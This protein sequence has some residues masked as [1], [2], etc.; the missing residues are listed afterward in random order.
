MIDNWQR[1]RAGV[2]ASA[3]AVSA[4]LALTGCFVS[5]G[6]FDAGL[7]LRRNG[8]FTFDYDGQIHVLELDDLS[9]LAANADPEPCLADDGQERPCTAQELDQ[10]KQDRVRE[11]EMMS[12]LLGGEDGA[13]RK[14]EELAEHL[15]R[16][17]GWN[18]VDYLGDGMFDVDFSV[19]GT[20]TY[21]FA[22][23]TIEGLPRGSEFVIAS[24]RDEAKVRIEAPGFSPSAS[25]TTIS[26]PSSVA[27]S[28]SA[29]SMASAMS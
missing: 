13:V 19:R 10:Q 9:Q 3:L 5:P 4:C 2:P 1:L 22:F 7:D 29:V 27:Q 11:A 17:A 20:L 24:L 23:P 28:F 15:S 16:Q 8:A 21:D 18:R 14:P 6:T 12:A 26:T 25:M